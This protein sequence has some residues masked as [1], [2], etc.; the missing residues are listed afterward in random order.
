MQKSKRL[1]AIS[2]SVFLSATIAACSTKP[3]NVRSSKDDTHPLQ[4]RKTLMVVNV[5]G[6]LSTP[7][8]EKFQRLL[9]ASLRQQFQAN[10]VKIETIHVNKLELDQGQTL[11]TAAAVYKPSELLEITFIPGDSFTGQNFAT[12][13]GRLR[14]ALS[15]A[16]LQ[17]IVW[18]GEVTLRLD[19]ELGHVEAAA[20]ELAQKLQQDGVLTNLCGEKI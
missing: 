9:F 18:N 7:E 20:T 12:K 13:Y 16:R 1:A 14:F 15:D 4:V 2:A 6:T 5:D 17:R 11:R 19:N 8:T 3:Y 10:C